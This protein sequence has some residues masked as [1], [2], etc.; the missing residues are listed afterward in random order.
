MKLDRKCLCQE[1]HRAERSDVISHEGVNT[2]LL[3][4]V[5]RPTLMGK[6]PRLDAIDYDAFETEDIDAL[7]DHYRKL[8]AAAQRLEQFV[9]AVA[10]TAPIPCKTRRFC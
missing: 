5:L 9:S 8:E 2:Y 1:F 4:K 7:A 6:P 10:S 3:E